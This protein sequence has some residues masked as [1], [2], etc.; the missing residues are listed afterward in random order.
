[1]LFDMNRQR[2]YQSPTM[3][4]IGYV[5]YEDFTNKFLSDDE[6]FVKYFVDHDVYFSVRHLQQLC[7]N[8]DSATL[9]TQNLKKVYGITNILQLHNNK[10]YIKATFMNNKLKIL[11]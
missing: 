10:P 7:E 6:A 11:N 4:E 5:T 3:L 1:M 8:T 9:F 2:L